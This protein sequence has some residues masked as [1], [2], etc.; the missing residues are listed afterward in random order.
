M[1]STLLHTSYDTNPIESMIEICRERVG[2]R[3]RWQDRQ[4]ALR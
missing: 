1:A 2:Q 4:M 3:Q